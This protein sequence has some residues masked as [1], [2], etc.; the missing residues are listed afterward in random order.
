LPFTAG[1][2]GEGRTFFML[3]DVPESAW[4]WVPAGALWLRYVWVR[5]KLRGTGF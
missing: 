5:R 1:D 2:F 3:R 4:L